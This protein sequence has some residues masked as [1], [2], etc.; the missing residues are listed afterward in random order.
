MQNDRG[1]RTEVTEID[2]LSTFA[3]EKQPIEDIE[4]FCRRL[5][6]SLTARQGR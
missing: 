6:N 1:I 4:Q 2:R 3:K 5:M